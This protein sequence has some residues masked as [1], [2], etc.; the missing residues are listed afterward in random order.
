MAPAAF[1]AQ[2]DPRE[3]RAREAFGAGRYEEAIDMFAK[4]Y[5]ETLHP[6]FLRNIGRC[7]QNLAIPGKAIA[8]FRE[9]LRKSTGM[10]AA[11]RAEV[12]GYIAEMEALQ[13][14]QNEPDPAPAAV[15]AAVTTPPPS[16]A[17][18]ATPAPNRDGEEEG[19]ITSKWWFWGTIAGVIVAGVV[20]GLAAGGV[21]SS[22]S[23]PDCAPPRMCI[24]N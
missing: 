15:P 13:K 22:P 19:G 1:A 21:F 20:V 14:R 6:T 18:L 24:G 8:S 10:P 4:L 9:Y 17:A 23:D 16:A 11:E 7:Y 5:A 2:S 3:M 12:Q